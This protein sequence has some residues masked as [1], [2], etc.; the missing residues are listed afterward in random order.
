M[1]LDAGVLDQGGVQ[2]I[3][4]L[5]IIALAEALSDGAKAAA[6]ELGI[7][8]RLPF[9]TIPYAYLCCCCRRSS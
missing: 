7:G 3:F 1:R 5:Y 8:K 6:T 9:T 2:A 4:H